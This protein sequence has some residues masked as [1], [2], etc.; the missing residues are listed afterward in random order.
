[1]VVEGVQKLH[2]PKWWDTSE[3]DNTSSDSAVR[4]GQNIAHMA[5]QGLP[6]GIEI[7]N[8]SLRGRESGSRVLNA[9]RTNMR[10]KPIGSREIRAHSAERSL[11]A[12]VQSMESAQKAMFNF[13]L[14]EIHLHLTYLNPFKND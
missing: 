13:P 2:C 3:S 8:D 6:N 9:A 14:C 11:G 10:R 5:V 4:G 12:P 7:P 1:M